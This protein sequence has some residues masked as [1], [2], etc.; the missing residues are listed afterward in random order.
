ML[1]RDYL[2]KRDSNS[3]VFLWILRNFQEHLFWKTSANGCFWTAVINN[4]KTSLMFIHRIEYMLL[5]KYLSC[6]VMRADI[7]KLRWRKY[8]LYEAS[9]L[10]SHIL[11]SFG[12]CVWFR[13]SLFW[14]SAQKLFLE[15]GKC[16]EKHMFWTRTNGNYRKKFL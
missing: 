5:F 7:M 16:L 12:Q 14:F 15:F 2:L 6:K 8:V 4:W 3:G 9:F 10:S 11:G 1:K 13:T